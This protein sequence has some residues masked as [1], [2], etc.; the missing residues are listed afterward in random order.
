[1]A[2]IWVK[3]LPILVL[4]SLCKIA[5]LQISAS[6]CRAIASIPFEIQTWDWSRLK[7]FLKILQNVSIENG[8]NC[9]LYLFCE[10]ISR[11][12]VRF[13]IQRCFERTDSRMI[14]TKFPFFLQGPGPHHCFHFDEKDHQAHVVLHPLH[15]Q[16]ITDFTVDFS[17]RLSQLTSDGTFISYATPNRFNELIISFIN[18]H[19]GNEQVHR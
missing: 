7:D 14:L 13:V 12:A 8:S 2:L 19:V 11:C 4:Q 18:V 15:D 6:L 1:M 5:F 16:P 17:Y 9:F 3:T 10:L